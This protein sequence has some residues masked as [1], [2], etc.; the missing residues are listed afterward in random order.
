MIKMVDYEDVA[1]E[2]INMKNRTPVDL[3]NLALSMN[4]GC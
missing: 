1:R 2:L 4:K 3:L